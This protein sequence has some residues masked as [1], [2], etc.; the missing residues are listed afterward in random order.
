MAIGSPD[1]AARLKQLRNYAR[2][3]VWSGFRSRDEVRAEVLEAV[4]DE[5]TDIDEARLLATEYVDD[6]ERSLAEAADAWPESTDYDRLQT[7]FAELEDAGIT[8]LQACEDHW[9]AQEMLQTLAAAGA[10]PRGIAY[11]THPDVWHAVD[12]G[13]LEINLWHGDSANVAP[14]DELLAAVQETFRR[15]GIESLFDEGR[16]ETSVAWQRRPLPAV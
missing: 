12:H 15:N 14:G 16:I 5:V 10:R 8:V 1:R 13:M 6:A 3:Q 2:V 4:R 9:S 11:F 7:A